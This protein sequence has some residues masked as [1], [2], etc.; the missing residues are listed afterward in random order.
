MFS[1]KPRNI[2]RHVIDLTSD[3]SAKS[4]SHTWMSE[5]QTRSARFGSSSRTTFSDRRQADAGRQ[6]IG[7][8]TDSKIAS[9]SEAARGDI[10]RAAK[11]ETDKRNQRFEKTPERFADISN[12]LPPQISPPA[13]TNS[14]SFYPDFR[15]KL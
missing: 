6:T 15:S 12:P 7:R 9:V 14:Q 13:P 2:V 8:Y 5:D 10:S 1:R 3:I 4:A 11:R